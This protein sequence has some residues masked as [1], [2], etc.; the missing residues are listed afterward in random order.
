M[1][2]KIEV[3]MQ[4]LQ[5]KARRYKL[6]K[7]TNYSGSMK[8]RPEFVKECDL[9]SFGPGPEMVLCND[10]SNL[11]VDGTLKAEVSLG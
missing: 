8:N 2:P 10:L 7:S 4:K 1:A 11:R 3:S 5:K 9:R 6:F